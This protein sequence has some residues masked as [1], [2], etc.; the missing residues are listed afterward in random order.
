[1]TLAVFA[2]YTPIVVD[3]RGAHDYAAGTVVVERTPSGP[4]IWVR[5][6]AARKDD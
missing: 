3:L 5:T 6:R 2:V 4:G 1:M